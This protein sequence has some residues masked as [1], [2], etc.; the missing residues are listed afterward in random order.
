MLNTILLIVF[1]IASGSLIFFVG[2]KIAYKLAEK[3]MIFTFIP[4][5]SFVFIAKG[6][7][8]ASISK[9]KMNSKGHYIDDEEEVKE[10]L[11]KI[12]NGTLY[13]IGILGKVYGFE[14][15]YGKFN[16][17]GEFIPGTKKIKFLKR[18]FPTAISIRDIEC[19]NGVKVFISIAMDVKVLRPRQL[20]DE[21]KGKY[22]QKIVECVNAAFE[23]VA[24]RHNAGEI[25]SMDRTILSVEI[26]KEISK[27]IKDV[28]VDVYNIF[29]HG[30]GFSDPI[31]QQT[32]EEAEL[33]LV[34]RDKELR[35]AQTRLE[36]AERDAKAS[37]LAQEAS[38]KDLLLLM[39]TFFE[40][41]KD[42]R[43]TDPDVFKEILLTAIKAQGL[44]EFKGGFIGMSGG[45]GNKSGGNRKKRGGN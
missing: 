16:E 24:V 38:T 25:I 40:K 9:I 3:D 32:V 4:N 8:V 45:Q 23:N 41:Y 1:V 37:A 27:R 10:S 18:V 2:V 7:T 17:Q 34:K 6:S 42:L 44:S 36:V 5:E 28:G 12:K 31:F 21:Y 30:V 26:S 15:N 14:I 19:R 43:K 39:D 29:T 22:Y 33:A 20:V 35:D 11:G 13:Y